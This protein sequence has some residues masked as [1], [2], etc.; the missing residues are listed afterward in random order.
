MNDVW[1]WIVKNKEWLFSG[2]GVLLLTL[3]IAFF[4]RKRKAIQGDII[5][6]HGDQSPGKV[7][8]DY[9]IGNVKSKKKT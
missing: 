7:G 2:I 6:T 1:N 4:R 5:S 8:G 9:I 3:L